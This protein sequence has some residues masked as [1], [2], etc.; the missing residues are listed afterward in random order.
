MAAHQLANGNATKIIVTTNVADHSEQ[1]HT[2][3]EKVRDVAVPQGFISLVGGDNAVEVDLAHNIQAM[4]PWAL[5]IMGSVV[6]VLLFLL[7]GSVFLP[8]KALLLN[9]LSLSATFGVLVWGFQDGHLQNILGFQ[10]IGSLDSTQTVLIFALAFALSMDY[11]VFLLSRIREQ[12]DLLHDNHEAIAVGLQRTGGLIT[13]AALLLAVV[14]G[15]F[16][17]S[18]IIFIQEIGVGVALAVLMDATLIRCLLVPAMMSLLSG[19]NWWA[20]KPLLALWRVIGL[21]ENG[22]PLTNDS[23]V[24]SSSFALPSS[25]KR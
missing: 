25:V 21:R 9:I 7:T 14:V 12:Y 5:L 6:L 13:C 19:I 17:V 1:A 8:S 11:E 2:L 20:P 15:T 22:S 18:K 16:A 23:A 3:V 24:P 10:S 4:I